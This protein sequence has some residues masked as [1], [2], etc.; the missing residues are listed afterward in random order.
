[1]MVTCLF[2]WFIFT[3]H[4]VWGHTLHRIESRQMTTY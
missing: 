4:G 2:I 3:G 1:M